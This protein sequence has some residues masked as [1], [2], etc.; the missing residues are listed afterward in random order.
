MKSIFSKII[1]REIPAKIIAENDEVIVIEDIAPKA[2]IHYLIIPKLEVRDIQS[3]AAQDFQVV[4][5]I[6]KMAQQLS[7]TVPGAEHF[8]LLIN[9]G[10]R[11]GQR[12]FHLHVH[13]LA[14]QL[15][16]D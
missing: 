7:R 4:E 3:L 6:F 13:F 10:E 16:G 1:A 9:N 12:V 8:R 11:A 2:A 5:P 14:G 15:L